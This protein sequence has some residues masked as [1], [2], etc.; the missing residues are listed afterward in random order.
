[1]NTKRT[2]IIGV[3][4]LVL[5]VSAIFS[6]GVKPAV[7]AC[8]S[9]NQ[10]YCLLAPLPG[11]GDTVDTTQG[12]GNYINTMI[13]IT[14]GLISVLA[15]LMLVVGGIQYMFSN[16][17]GEK[18]GAK[19]RMTNAI[20]GL[21]L[22]LSSYLILN[23]INPK[24]VHITIGVA[25]TTLTSFP[26]DTPGHDGYGAGKEILDKT[27]GNK[28]KNTAGDEI[29]AG[30]KKDL[31]DYGLYHL[32]YFASA[33]IANCVFVEHL[34]SN[35]IKVDKNIEDSLKIA[36]NHWKDVKESDKAKYSY[37]IQMMVGYSPD[38]APG[39]NVLQSSHTFGLAVDIGPTPL[40]AELV[41]SM[42]SYGGFGWGGDFKPPAKNDPGHFSKIT[43]EGAVGPDSYTFEKSP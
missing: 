17:A 38:L 27:I 21:I 37:T 5:F 39:N 43:S 11:L 16:I 22:M 33:C 6:F 26:A 10:N 41:T 8:V 40:P 34:Q 24:L 14:I 2:K 35:N 4:I 18:A 13:K 20:F 1:M 12:V 36:F 28:V 15:V 29:V 25:T 19:S 30:S 31:D 9:T 42:K 32:E 23:T 7:A 3:A